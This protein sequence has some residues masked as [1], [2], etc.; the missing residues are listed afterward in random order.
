MALA[1]HS[2]IRWLAPNELYDVAWLPAD[3][4]I[5]EEISKRLAP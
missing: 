3:L 2:A 4:P 1:D 5:V